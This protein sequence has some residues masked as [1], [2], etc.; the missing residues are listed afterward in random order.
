[1]E[2]TPFREES[3]IFRTSFSR[4]AVNWG[5]FEHFLRFNKNRIY[6]LLNFIIIFSQLRGHARI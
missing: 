3:D 4:P 5:Y 6:V 1:M 2:I